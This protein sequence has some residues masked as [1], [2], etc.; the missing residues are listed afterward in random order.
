MKPAGIHNTKTI[1]FYSTAHSDNCY[2][3]RSFIFRL[4][5]VDESRELLKLFLMLKEKITFLR[6]DMMDAGAFAY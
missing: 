5:S 2:P 3:R 6:A 1:C 4:L